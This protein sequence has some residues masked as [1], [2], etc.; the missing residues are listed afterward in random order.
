MRSVGACLL[1]VGAWWGGGGFRCALV[2]DE[3]EL[4]TSVGR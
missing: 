1:G 4:A 2:E 3:D